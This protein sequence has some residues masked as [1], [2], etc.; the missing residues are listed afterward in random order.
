MVRSDRTKLSGVVEIDEAY[1]GG[2]EHGASIGRDT[3]NKVLVVLAVELIQTDKPNRKGLQPLGRIRLAVVE[4]ASRA[5]LF[6]FIE[7]NIEK[8]SKIISDG[9]ASYS[10]LLESSP[11]SVGKIRSKISLSMNNRLFKC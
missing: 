2:E 7:D 1:I 10:T 9:W 11:I 6:P 4:N 8:G 5:S 3:G